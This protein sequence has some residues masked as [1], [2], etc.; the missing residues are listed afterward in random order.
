M[1][2]S[3]III[4][5]N[6]P[7]ITEEAIAKCFEFGKNWLHE[8]ILID[9]NSEKSVS[10]DFIAQKNIIYIKNNVNLGFAKAVN[11]G[12]KK[13]NG[14]FILLLN[15]DVIIKE[16]TVDRMINVLNEDLQIGIVGP[17]FFHSQGDIQPSSGYFPN[18]LREFLRL[19]SFWKLIPGST[20]YNNKSKT[21]VKVD[22]V[23]GG[24]MLIR[25]ELINK[26]GL[27]DENYFFGIED[28]D[29]C[30]R[31]KEAGYEVAYSPS[32]EIIHYHG[33]SS[34]GKRS[35]LSLA[36]E[37]RGVN[38]FFN[39]HYHK[40]KITKRLVQLLY[41]IKIKVLSIFGF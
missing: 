41:F 19:S 9:N 25:K 21:K 15:S 12:I 26:I 22:W 14:D 16:K 8:V 20:L 28:W 37:A 17:R 4:N 39:K 40:K 35:T 30:W 10:D 23:S 13:S 32:A 5:Y 3:V 6:T 29:F 36:R 18:L 33:L 38:Y 7:G 1:R 2:T 24:C 27:L 31:A 11:Q 34:G